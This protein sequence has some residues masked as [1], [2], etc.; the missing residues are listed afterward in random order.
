[1]SAAAIEGATRKVQALLRRQHTL[2][3]SLLERRAQLRGSLITRW[4]RC[5]KEGCACRRGPG[6]GPYYVLSTR[7]GGSG[8]FTYL[9]REQVPS[10]RRLVSDY[11]QFQS[12]LRRLRTLNDEL[13]RSMGRYQEAAARLARRRVGLSS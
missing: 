1:M 3:S 5:G 4:A 13:L 11:R 6:H 10:A 2:V 7:S 9:G 12:G 8:A